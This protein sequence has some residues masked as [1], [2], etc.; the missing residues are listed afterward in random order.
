VLG[1]RPAFGTWQRVVLVDTNTD[2]PDRQVRL[3]F[4]AD[5]SAQLA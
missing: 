3:S 1:G 4:V 2:N 5:A